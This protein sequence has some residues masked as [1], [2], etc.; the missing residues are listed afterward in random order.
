MDE[1]YSNA[2][3]DILTFKLILD[4]NNN[5]EEYK[6]NAKYKVRD[7]EIKEVEKMLGC[8]DVEK[9]YTSYIC[10]ACGEIIY[11]PHSCKSRICTTCGKR[12]ADEWAEMINS[13]LYAVPY[14]QGKR[15]C[16]PYK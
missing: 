8:M 16:N 2:E 11:I 14:R 3:S 4:L 6:K 13:E 10:Q 7:V 12:H 9:G 1:L 5:W 15:I